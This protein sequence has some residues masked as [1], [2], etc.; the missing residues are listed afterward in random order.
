MWSAVLASAALAACVA[1]SPGQAPG[2][3]AGEATPDGRPNVVLLFSDQHRW[4]SMGHTTMPELATPAMDRLATEGLSLRYAIS[5]YPVCA[6]ARAMLL[7]GRWPFQ[8]GVTDNPKELDPDE[9][10]IADAFASAGYV[11][12]YIG[13]WHLG[14]RDAKPFGFEHS[15]VWDNTSNHWSSSYRVAGGRAGI[16]NGYNATGMTDQAL[17]FLEEHRGDPFLLIVSW[18]PPHPRLRDAP[19]E[20]RALYRHGD[21]SYRDNVGELWRSQAQ[22]RDYG[23]YHAHV[24]AVDDELA[25]VVAKLEELEL[26]RR[27]IVVYTSDHGTML[28]SHGYGVHKRLFYDEAIRVP[29]LLRWPERVPG[30][31]DAAARDVLLGMPD[32]FPTLCGLAGVDVPESVEGEDRSALFLGQD[33]P[34]PTSA[35]LVHVDYEEE[36]AKGKR[37]PRFRGLRT[38]RHTLAVGADGTRW[39]FDNEADPMQRSNLA[40]DDGFREVRASLE[41]E[42]AAWL[43]K[44]SDPFPLGQP[45]SGD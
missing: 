44:T 19:K 17:E 42:L 14:G 21:L 16:E 10:T 15:I 9:T 3:A 25:R 31:P 11:T 6:P 26:S 45:G 41:D 1:S 35:L 24:S 39:L 28:G 4:H 23:G 7:T 40:D 22:F 33:A 37:T 30:G 2:Q 38:H 43:R 18:N 13:K 29:F 12:G 32:V 8:T 5:S 20:K 34:A 36:G 27:T